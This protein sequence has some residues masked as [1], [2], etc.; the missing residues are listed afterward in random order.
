MEETKTIYLPENIKEIISRRSTRDPQTRFP[1]KLYALLSYVSGNPELEEEIGIAWV[2]NEIFQ[3]CKAKLLKVMQI[4]LNT[5]NVNLK[6]GKFKQLHCEKHGWTRW[7]RDGFTKRECLMSN[8]YQNFNESG[9]MDISDWK[10]YHK[11][12]TIQSEPKEFHLGKMT[13]DQIDMVSQQALK[14]WIEIIESDT[15]SYQASTTYFVPQAAKRYCAPRQ[16]YQNSF[17]V[18]MAIFAPQETSFIRFDDFYRIYA[19]FGPADTLM[20]KIASLLECATTGTHWLY[21]GQL[22]TNNVTVYGHID[23]VESN[24]LVIHEANGNVTKVWNDPFKDS[25]SD[26]LIDQNDN[27]YSSWEQYF[28]VHPINETNVYTN[29]EIEEF[30]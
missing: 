27:R 24:C 3:I 9:E 6:I 4:K 11:D 17:E 25:N 13:P 21:F 5:L 23:E 14:E 12:S 30:H 26:Y 8:S 10:Q 2:D 28:R 20:L 29:N 19:F 16:S 18:L 22:P 1:A 7:R 15:F